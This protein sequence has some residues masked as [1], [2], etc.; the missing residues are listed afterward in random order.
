MHPIASATASGKRR[1]FAR[2]TGE[3]G[4]SCL[5]AIDMQAGSGRGP[6]LDAVVPIA[7]AGPDGII[8]TWHVARRFP[9]AF[10]RVGLILRVDGATTHLGETVSGDSFAM[11]FT[12]EQAAVVGADAVIMMVFPGSVDEGASLQRLA[13]LVGEAERIGMPVIAESIPGGFARGVPWDVEHLSRAARVC[14]EHG[15]DAVK[16]PAPP[17]VADV[18]AVVANCDGPLFVLGGPKAESDDDAVRHAGAAVAAGAAGIAFGRNVW[19]ADDPPAV[20]RRLHAAVHADPS[21]AR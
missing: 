17:D 21:G 2:F 13:R 16:T 4:R 3:D 9:E 15:A 7:A 6:A 20:V 5:V 1:R 18:A 19:Q 10:R 11:A 14:I 8:T 12:A